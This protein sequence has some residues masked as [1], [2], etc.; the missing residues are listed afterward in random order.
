[1]DEAPPLRVDL[2]S[3]AYPIHFGRD[4]LARAGDLLRAHVEADRA[5]IV[6]DSNL[7]AAGHLDALRGGLGRAGI[8]ACAIR[9]DPGESAKR[10]DRLGEVLDAMLGFGVER[11]TL[12]IALGGGVVG[13]LGG[14]AAAVAL[15]GLDYVQ[16]PTTLLAQVDSAVG[17]KTGINSRHG[18]NLIGAFHQPVAVLVD[19]ALLD[20]LPA[21]ELRAGYAEIVKYGCIED[22]AFFAWLEANGPRVLARETGALCCAVRR[23]LEIKA[24]IVAED[25]RETSGRRALLNFGHTFAHAYEALAGYDGRLL[26]GEAVA[27][28]MVCAAKLSALVGTA[29]GDDARRLAA[30]LKASGLP[31]GTAEAGV[32]PFEAD[33][34]IGAMARDKKVVGG[35]VGFVLWQGPGA[36]EA[37]IEVDVDLVRRVL[38]GRG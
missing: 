15:R 30:H 1:M 25:E 38:D 35:K 10:L 11:R 21:R 29:G 37:G 34:L 26:H 24:M 8:E 13:D 14:F 20:T 22:A 27:L 9:V 16:I 7:E 36:A 17:G 4:L 28:G 5:V 2:G 23:S 18:K 19:F 31:T 3:R 33:A 32:G 6:T 12:V